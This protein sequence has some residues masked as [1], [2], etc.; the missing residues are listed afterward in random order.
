MGIDTIVD[1]DLSCDLA[2][3]GTYAKVLFVLPEHFPP[4]LSLPNDVH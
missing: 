2:Y 1:P 4:L 3:L